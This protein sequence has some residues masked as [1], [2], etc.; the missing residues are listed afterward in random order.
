MS[1]NNGQSA[2]TA[3]A[4]PDVRGTQI[5]QYGQRA[6]VQEIVDRLLALH[7]AS[8]EVGPAGMKSVAQLAVLSGASPLPGTNEIHVWK[9]KRTGKIQTTLGINYFR[10]RAR[11]LGG[12]FWSS[13][14]RQMN[15]K[16]RT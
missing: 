10:R 7:P 4:P 6:E 5:E 12:V 14:P 1:E 16:E 11:E 15:P 9:N 13:R 2:V 8:D 3:L